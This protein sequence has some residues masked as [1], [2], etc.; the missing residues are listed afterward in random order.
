MNERSNKNDVAIKENFLTVNKHAPA[1]NGWRYY[2]TE[3]KDKFK[4]RTLTKFTHQFPEMKIQRFNSA[5]DSLFCL[6]AI[7]I[8]AVI[9][10]TTVYFVN[11]Y[12]H[13]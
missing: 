4:M 13:Q 12:I 10:I 8:M 7:S 11:T 5:A 6:V 3:E 2:E 1:D 9:G